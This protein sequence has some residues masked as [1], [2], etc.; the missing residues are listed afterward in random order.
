MLNLEEALFTVVLRYLNCSCLN[1]FI[2]NSWRF[3]NLVN[4]SNLQGGFNNFDRNC[5]GVMEGCLLPAVF[6][7]FHIVFMQIS[8]IHI[9]LLKCFVCQ[10]A[11]LGI[12]PWNI[13]LNNL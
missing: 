12:N 8:I 4:T 6:S 10:V 2:V 5:D 11:S 9:I 1:V 13:S 7:V 3:V